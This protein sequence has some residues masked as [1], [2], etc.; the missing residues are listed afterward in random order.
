MRTI[1]AALIWELFSRSRWQLL[2]MTCAGSLLPVLIYSAL[3]TQGALAPGDSAFIVM[4]FALVQ[5]NM[6]TFG[7]GLMQSLGPMSRLYAYPARTST[8]V[9]WQLLPA[10][11]LM[12]LEM[13]ATSAA[14][15]AVYGVRWPIWG[16][17]LFAAVAL[18]AV[19]ATMW[20]TERSAWL[21]WAVGLVA[22]ALGIWLKTRYGLLSNHPTHYWT[23]VT[24]WD[25]I[26]LS[27]IAAASYSVAVYGVSR[28]RRGDTWPAWGARAWL[29]R[30][31]ESASRDNGRFQSPA[32]AQ[33]W[34]EW[35]KKGWAMPGCVVFVMLMG[36]LGW[37]IFSREPRLF[38][39]Q[40]FLG[41]GALMCVLGLL[42][43]LI[44]GDCGTQ[45][46]YSAEMGHF[47]ATR[48]MSNARL[49]QLMLWN[50]AK[51]VGAAWLLWAIPAL[52]LSVVP[53]ATGMI[54]LPDLDPFVMQSWCWYLP[55]ALIG[56]WTI[57]T[58]LAAL[59]MTGRQKLLFTLFFGGFAVLLGLNLFAEYALSQDQKLTFWRGVFIGFSGLMVLGTVLLF[60][61]AR[62]RALIGTPTVWASL[63]AWSALIAGLVATQVNDPQLPLAACV[64]IGGMLALAVAPF[65]GTP[66][67]LA[68]N[69][70][71]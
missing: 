60:A 42:G 15:N 66:L 32:A 35:R 11:A 19:V 52:L 4:H 31:S 24:V 28:N 56:S 58:C 12:M 49:A 68:W 45:N 20:L 61:M 38:I 6:F 63:A 29:E 57:T 54:A 53:V 47:L 17:S 37:S 18:S 62:R 55:V 23:V 46:Y 1:P 2:L 51:S 65:A 67:A 48:P 22:A 34:F 16:P 33:S 39:E 13:M 30:V 44:L 7:A 26:W 41:G 3:R 9:A 70:T 25:G 10:M 43:G 71:R 8:L 69:R 64:C 14:L 21:P 5:V 50:S 59:A 27:L 40:L 36:L